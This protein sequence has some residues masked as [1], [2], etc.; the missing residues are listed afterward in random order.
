MTNEEV[1]TRARSVYY[2]H[3]DIGSNFC[4]YY[5]KARWEQQLAELPEEQRVMLVEHIERWEA[6][7]IQAD[8]SLVVTL[9]EEST[10]CQKKL[11]N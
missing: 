4:M 10:Q 11:G 7:R 3:V 8:Q 1:L 6:M 5:G 2:A 9:R